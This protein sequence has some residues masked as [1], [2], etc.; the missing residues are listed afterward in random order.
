MRYLLFMI[1]ALLF[2][3]TFLFLFLFLDEI[4]SHVASEERFKELPHS[5]IL[6]VKAVA[7]FLSF[8]IANVIKIFIYN[9]LLK[10]DLFRNVA[11]DDCSE[12]CLKLISS[13]HLLPHEVSREIFNKTPD[14][15][16]PERHRGFISS[17]LNFFD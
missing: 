17:F 7:L 5:Y 4:I 14:N 12:K 1:K 2:L 8:S 9:Y 6:T 11:I 16:I 13:A 10:F 15:Q 3:A